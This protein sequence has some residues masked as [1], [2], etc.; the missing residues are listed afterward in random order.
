MMMQWPDNHLSL[1]HSTGYNPGVSASKEV[2]SS[3]TPAQVTTSLH[4]VNSK[5]VNSGELQRETSSTSSSS[6]SGFSTDH[7]QFCL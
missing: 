3:S 1:S 4:S 6:Q 2:S 7:L 5:S